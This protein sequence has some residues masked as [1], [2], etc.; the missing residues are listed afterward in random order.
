M[1]NLVTK[2]YIVLSNVNSATDGDK[3]YKGLAEVTIDW[4]GESFRNGLVEFGKWFLQGFFYL[5]QP[6]FEWG[7]KSIIVASIVIYFCSQDKKCIRIGLKYFFIYLAYM[8][9]RSVVQ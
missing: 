9:I 5:S 4:F 2:F 7:C 1:F 8:M 3:D 6:F